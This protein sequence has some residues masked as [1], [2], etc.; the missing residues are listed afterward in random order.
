MFASINSQ[1]IDSLSISSKENSIFSYFEINP[2]YQEYS[3]PEHSLFNS[4]EKIENISKIGSNESN[5]S[6]TNLI[7]RKR[8]RK[9]QKENKKERPTHDKSARDNIRRKIQIHYLKFLIK[10]VNKIIDE[11]LNQD[12]KS[13]DYH[14]NPL[15]HKFTKQIS[16]KSFI[17]IRNASIGNIFKNNVSPKFNNF[18]QLN[19]NVYNNIINKNDK[20]KNILDKKYL[21]FFDIYYKNIKQINLSDY[22]INDINKIINLSSE[23][24]LFEDLLKTELNKNNCTINID[25]YF[26][27]IEKCIKKDFDNN[28]S[29]FVVN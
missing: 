27:K 26:E 14:F 28:K 6:D 20:I 17:E 19:V 2:D 29:I 16:K 13:K 12:G 1:D 15:S 22:G 10:F 25:K 3:I 11:L 18:E 21:H 5:T 4:K 23:I 8:G 9:I 7:K 24:E